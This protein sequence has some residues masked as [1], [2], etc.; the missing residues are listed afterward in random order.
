MAAHLP[1][2]KDTIVRI[3][4]MSKLITSTAVLML[5]EEGRFN[6]DDPVER[7]VPALARPRVFVGRD[8]GRA[9]PG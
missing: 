6:L 3:Y 8:R 5:M 1:M 2:E 9:D 7:Y 4:S